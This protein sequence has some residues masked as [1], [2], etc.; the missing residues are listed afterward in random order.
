MLTPEQ[1][2]DLETQIRAF[3]GRP[4][5]PPSVGRDL[6]NEPMIRQWCD[7]TGD[8][9][10]VYLDPEAAAKSVHGGIVA[11][12]MMLQAWILEGWSMHRG[13][14]EPRDEQQRLHK[15]LTDAGYTGVLGTDTEQTFT[16]YL[17]PGD[18]VSA[19]TVIADISEEKATGVGVG[20]FITTRTTFCDAK[21]IELG[22]MNFRVLKFI[23]KDAPQSAAANADAA[24]A[25]PQKPTRIKP[26]LSH[27]NAWWWRAVAEGTLLPLQRCA[28]CQKL[29]HPPR[30]MC[31]DCGATQWDHIAASGRGALHSYT[32]IHHPR[33]PGYEFPILAALVDL[34]EGCR[35]V[36]NV[37]DC[38]PGALR[39]GMALQAFIH[40]D[41]DGFRLPLFRP[42][43]P[44]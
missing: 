24:D 34:P 40:E 44:A 14:D 3:V 39:I 16:R 13:H 10:P 5:G 33:F 8:A 6:V 4:T 7:A 41:E 20:Y 17:R 29:R 38:E 19:E 2:R 15:I 18:Q 22:T 31:D 43:E 42:A 36:S 35:I 1:K 27:D 32:V 23:P 21:G 11:P 25:Q 30:P 26:P 12:P 37:V 28:Q 9:N